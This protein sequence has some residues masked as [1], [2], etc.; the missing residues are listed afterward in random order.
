[1]LAELEKRD[2]TIDQLEG[3]V[4]TLQAELRRKRFSLKRVALSATI[5]ANVLLSA[6]AAVGIVHEVKPAVVAK[7]PT[8]SGDTF[9]ELV[10]Q[11]DELRAVIEAH[12]GHDG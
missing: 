9:G 5:V 2:A 11:C 12:G 8:G 6:N 10:N 1:M 7:A 4:R 3:Q